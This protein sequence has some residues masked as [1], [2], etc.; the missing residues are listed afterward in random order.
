MKCIKDFMI[1]MILSIKVMINSNQWI[2][3]TFCP[4]VSFSA[5]LFQLYPHN[6]FSSLHTILL[7]S[8]AHFP[9][10]KQ[11]IKQHQLFKPL[12][13]ALHFPFPVPFVFAYHRFIFNACVFISR[14]FSFLPSKTAFHFSSADLWSRFSPCSRKTNCRS[15][16]LP[17]KFELGGKLFPH[18][19]IIVFLPRPTE[20]ALLHF[21]HKLFKTPSLTG[22]KSWHKT[23]AKLFQ[24]FARQSFPA[25][26]FSKVGAR[27]GVPNFSR[28]DADE[29]CEKLFGEFFPRKNFANVENFLLSFK[30]HH[31]YR[32]FGLEVL[33]RHCG[34]TGGNSSLPSP[35]LQRTDDGISSWLWWNTAP[36]RTGARE[37]A[38]IFQSFIRFA[39]IGEWTLF[40]RRKILKKARVQPPP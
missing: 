17:E 18:P 7:V 29:G 34:T 2:F 15:P 16:L 36:A 31:Q 11:I 1:E 30:E 4:S 24:L 8:I 40:G 21:S 3:L 19:N 10:T 20:R 26:F 27:R 37:R 22:G 35:S 5:D 12:F 39:R 38:R 6:T 28:D 25:K 14:D 33:A 13:R 9:K 23:F 32:H